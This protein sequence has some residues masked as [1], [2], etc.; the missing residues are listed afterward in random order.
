MTIRGG[1][2][3]G[4]DIAGNDPADRP[5]RGTLLRIATG[6]AEF[7]GNTFRRLGVECYCAGAAAPFDSHGTGGRE[8]HAAGPIECVPLGCERDSGPSWLPGFDPEHGGKIVRCDP[9]APRMAVTASG[10]R[11]FPP[12]GSVSGHHLA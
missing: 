4:R 2:R 12:R 1:P 11:V 8:H 7:D 6:Q 10:I 5:A 9:R 3:S